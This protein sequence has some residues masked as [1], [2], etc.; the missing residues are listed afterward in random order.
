MKSKLHILLPYYNN[1]K[2]LREAVQSIVHQTVGHWRLTIIDDAG[3]EDD[4]AW[5][6]SLNDKRIEYIRNPKNL[7]FANNFQKCLELAEGEWCVVMGA[8]DKMKADFV[9]RFADNRSKLVNVDFYQPNV[10]VIDGAGKIYRPLGDVVKALLRPKKSGVYGGDRALARLMT[11]NYLYFPSIVWRVEAAKKC[12]FSDRFGTLTDLE[13]AVKIIMAGE[14]YYLDNKQQVFQYRR[15]NSVSTKNRLNGKFYED[16]DKFYV[17]ATE[18]FRAKG[19]H[20]AARAA[21][22][23]L[24]TR[25]ARWF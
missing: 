3:P 13:L 12:G 23:R 15:H 17:W 20:R 14:R 7:G 16:E 25:L 9:E 5:T 10:E 8:D 21:K 22:V 24:A 6:R 2:Y 1:S 19:F 11:G 4:S 18:R